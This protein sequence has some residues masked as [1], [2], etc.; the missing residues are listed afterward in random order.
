MKR[1]RRFIRW[2]VLVG[3]SGMLPAFVLNCDKAALQIQRGFLY[4]LGEQ[5]A[6]L[7]LDAG[8]LVPNVPQ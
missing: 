3:A 5:A 8:L 2:V 4:G 6:G 7:V 1:S